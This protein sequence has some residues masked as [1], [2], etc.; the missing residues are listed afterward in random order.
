M[1]RTFVLSAALLMAACTRSPTQIAEPVEQSF[2]FN[3]LEQ[4]IRIR[5]MPAETDPE[6]KWFVLTSRIVNRGDV[7]VA[8]DAVTCWLDPKTDLRSDAEF[9][10]YAIPSCPGRSPDDDGILDPGEAT[11][12][13]FFA[14]RIEEP[15]RYTI[16][17]R[18]SRQPEFWGEITVVAR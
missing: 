10:S 9:S 13:A 5:P 1:R 6:G 4:E 2:T 11:R 17:V 7:P 18:Q 8:V 15:G 12:S 16:A 3:G 14:G